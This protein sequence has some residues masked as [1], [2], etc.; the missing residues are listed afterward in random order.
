MKTTIIIALFL[1][2]FTAT[3]FAGVPHRN[4]LHQTTKTITLDADFNKVSVAANLKVVFISNDSKDATI[5]GNSKFVETINFQILNGTLF[6]STKSNITNAK[7]IIYVPVKNL[8]EI[9][10]LPGAIISTNGFLNCSYLTVLISE[11]SH[12]E[13][14]NKGNL[15]FKPAPDSELDFVRY[16]SINE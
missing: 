4:I 3:S 16:Q 14:R 11:D 8:A 6:I 7:G 15:V 1:S 10:L 2:L 12:A 5:E 13:I 9:N